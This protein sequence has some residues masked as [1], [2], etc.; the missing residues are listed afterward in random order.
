MLTGPIGITNTHSVGV[1]RD[2]IIRS[3][4]RRAPVRDVLLVAAGRR[5]D[6]GRAAQRHRRLPRHRGPCRR[7]AGGA[8]PAAR[9]RRRT[10]AAGPGW[11]ATS[12]RAGSGRRRGSST[13]TS[14]GWTVGVLVQANYGRRD[15]LR[16]D[17]VPVGEAIPRRARSRART[18]RPTMTMARPSTPPPGSGLDHRASSRPTRRCCPTSASGWRS[19]PA[20]ASLGWAAPARHSSGDLF[21]CFATGNRSLPRTSFRADP[22]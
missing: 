7:G 12:S 6:V 17:G 1:V 22:A 2:A 16:I 8:R 21:L 9:R 3:A 13:P 20:W 5:R 11:S 19:G 14:G 4:V 10:S 18:A 15:W